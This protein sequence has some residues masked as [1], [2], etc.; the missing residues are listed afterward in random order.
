MT[1]R[2]M[3]LAALGVAAVAASSHA[4]WTVVNMH[5]SWAARST[6]H[7]ISAGQ[8]V[9]DVWT[10]I[11]PARYRA[12]VWTGSSSSCTP[13]STLSGTEDSTGRGVAVGKQIGQ[14]FT[15]GTWRA[16]LW[17]GS[18]DSW[19]DL[20]P[21]GMIQSS[22]LTATDGL[23]HVGV[24]WDGGSVRALLWSGTSA[25]ATD[26]HVEGASQTRALGVHAG[27]QVGYAYWIS[28]QRGIPVL[29]TGTATSW[30]DLTPAGT[31]GG[32][33]FAAFAGT[34]VGV[35]HLPDPG[36]ARASLWHGTAE[37]WTNLHPSQLP[38]TSHSWAYAAHADCQAGSTY[39]T[40]IGQEQACIWRGS[41]DTWQS[42]HFYL[43][44]TFSSSTARGVWSD[45]NS[46]YVVGWGVSNGRI[47]ALMWTGSL[48][49]TRIVEQ[50]SNQEAVPGAPVTFI[51][52]ASQPS[53]CTIPLMYQWQRRDP[54][55]TDDN[56]P[57]AWISLTEGS[58]YLNVDRPALTV[59]NPTPGLAGPFRCR[60]TGTCGCIGPIYSDIIDFTVTCPAD[61]NADGGIDFGDVEAFFERWENGC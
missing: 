44:T 27:Q 33:A 10:S 40:E 29:W 42:L 21:G 55:I 37:S 53:D 36:G 30:V 56:A 14:R 32:Q 24:G 12:A 28:P 25:A 9:G 8:Q 61:F 58:G 11:S 46:V 4:Q 38:A 26:L 47:E 15:D 19:R 2:W 60:I 3:A 20:H 31:V 41:A 51:V 35:A 34:Q 23:Q 54:R 22:E 7:G 49:T 43:P 45:G 39:D 5:P 6:L 17:T 18:S 59:T 50:P 57:D 13:L 48:C 52:N 1:T 16:S